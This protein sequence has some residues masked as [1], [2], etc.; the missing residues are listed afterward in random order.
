MGARL[1]LALLGG[2]S[3]R[4]SAD[5]TY[6]NVTYFSWISANV[7]EDAPPNAT[8]LYITTHADDGPLQEVPLPW[9]FPLFG[10]NIKSVWV[11]P[12]G[13][14]FDSRI[15]P[16]FKTNGGFSEL[17]DGAYGVGLNLSSFYY[18]AIAPFATD[19]YPYGSPLASVSY[20][21]NASRLTVRFSMVPLYYDI[22]SGGPIPGNN[23]FRASL[24]SDG[25]IIF[26]YDSVV[27]ILDHPEFQFFSGLRDNLYPSGSSATFYTASQLSVAGND[28]KTDIPGV[29]PPLSGVVSGNQFTVCPVSTVWAVSPAEFD[30]S[31]LSAASAA[32]T[33]TPLSLGCGSLVRFS[34]LLEGRSDAPAPCRL[35]NASADPSVP[36]LS[37]DASSWRTLSLLPGIHNLS[38]FWAQDASN[39]TLSLPNLTLNVTLDATNAAECAVNAVLPLCN[40]CEVASGNFSCL[41][42]PCGSVYRS[43]SC[44]SDCSFAYSLDFFGE[45]CPTLRQDCAG[46]C[47]NIAV[48]AKR[49]TGEYMCC[50]QPVDCLGV[51]GGTATSD[52]E[53]V[54]QGPATK[55]RCGVC[56]GNNQSCA[57]NYSISINGMP[58]FPQ[59]I[60]PVLSVL[61]P[62][63]SY[64]LSIWNN[65]NTSDM[66]ITW[67]VSGSADSAPSVTF[68]ADL[69][70][71]QALSMASVDFNISNQKLFLLQ[72]N[73]WEV[74]QIELSFN[75]K[76][77]SGIS[78]TRNITIFPST[79]NCSLIMR[80]DLC[81]VL[82]AC[83]F[84]LRYPSI[85][86]LQEL[87]IH[88]APNYALYSRKLFADV[89][90]PSNGF[91]LPTYDDSL[92]GVCSPGWFP[93]DCS[94]EILD[95]YG[96]SSG[97]N[98]CLRLMP[99]WLH[100]L[101]LIIMFLC[102]TSDSLD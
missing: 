90:P 40:A 33:L 3:L 49:P 56:N 55:D 22:S 36:V 74:K 60:T 98:R 69:L 29:Y 78:Q 47:Q 35:T 99:W 42:D 88:A 2:L 65:N 27:S 17:L 15:P 57:F 52:C 81:M 25:H 68:S 54:C 73:R 86:L 87:E 43:S 75:F 28:W 85:R 64:Q 51:C 62:W 13:A 14:L 50:D 100:V 91:A 93:D 61:Q 44:A 89:V 21:S 9:V 41:Q 6:S 38:V 94:R 45:C 4:C 24:H 8:I 76:G 59:N 83:I 67:A 10:R 31:A 96:A 71:V 23:S 72:Q 11:S 1:A 102:W 95:T 37:C 46:T 30:A 53:G 84:C 20:Y 19:L 97:G 34:V 101:L 39:G 63:R 26:N 70:T 82:P 16:V 58:V 12:N 77:I 48:V 66:V 7:P 80:R 79:N 5:P 18:G 92:Y 32:L